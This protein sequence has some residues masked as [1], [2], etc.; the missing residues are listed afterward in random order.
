MVDYIVE[1]YTKMNVET[2]NQ[3]LRFF[4]RVETKMKLKIL[5]LQKVT[6]HKLKSVFRDEENELLTL[7][8]LLLAIDEITKSLDEVNL[9]AVKLRGRNK[10][11]QNKRQKLLGYWA[12]FKKLKI[13]QGMSYRQVSEYFLKYHRLRISASLL[14]QMWLELEKNTDM[15]N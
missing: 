3:R 1:K 15:E 5:R 10:R 14:C 7:A 12:I 4:V 2:Q 11:A 8:S 6:F 9:N 13:E